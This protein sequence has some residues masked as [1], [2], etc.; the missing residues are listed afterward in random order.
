MI[1][2]RDAG[3]SRPPPS[4]EAIAADVANA[5][6]VTLEDLRSD[7]RRPDLVRAR[8]EIARRALLE[9]AANLS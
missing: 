9:G 5:Q 2:P 6:A 4:L 1:V 8:S 7:R 3:R